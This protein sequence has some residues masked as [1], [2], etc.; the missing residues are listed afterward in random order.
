MKWSMASKNPIPS[1][2]PTADG[3]TL[4]K[5]S[6]S[7]VKS[8]LGRS[9]DQNEAATITPEAKPRSDFC[10]TTFI[11]WRMKNTNDAPMTV[12][13][14]GTNNPIAIPS[15]YSNYAAKL[16]I[17]LHILSFLQTFNTILL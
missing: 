4:I 1:R 14:K 13:K 11:S 6:A 7:A 2:N 8:R 9:S 16:I 15:I 17:F 12:P 3:I 5:P 10:H